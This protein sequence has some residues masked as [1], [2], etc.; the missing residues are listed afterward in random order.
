[1]NATNPI[2]VATL[3]RTWNRAIRIEERAIERGASESVID[4]AARAS[5]RARRALSCAEAGLPLPETKAPRTARNLGKAGLAAL[6]TLGRVI[7]RS[8][9]RQA[10]LAKARAAAVLARA[11][12][13]AR[14]AFRRALRTIV[15]L[16]TT[17]ESTVS[18]TNLMTLGTSTTPAL[19]AG[20]VYGASSAILRVTDRYGNV[21]TLIRSNQHGLSVVCKLIG[22]RFVFSGGIHGEHCIDASAAITDATRL[23][24]HWGG[25]CTNNGLLDW[26]VLNIT[27]TGEAYYRYSVEGYNWCS[28]QTFTWR[29]RDLDDERF[30]LSRIAPDRLAQLGLLAQACQVVAS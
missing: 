14:A 19:A 13:L 2:L 23:L 12:K 30:D 5:D 8:V 11:A 17:K 4:R 24:S 16:V 26:E 18:K 3:T 27:A 20:I 28:Q 1:M 10:A 22:D 21:H 9:A 29:L 25:Y 15:S 6:A 7:A